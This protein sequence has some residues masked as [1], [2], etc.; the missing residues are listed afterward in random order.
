MEDKLVMLTTASV[1]DALTESATLFSAKLAIA[2]VN[3]ELTEEQCLKVCDFFGDALL[4]IKTRLL[5]NP[6]ENCQ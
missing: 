3:N 4:L 6:D 1:D 5:G 2:D